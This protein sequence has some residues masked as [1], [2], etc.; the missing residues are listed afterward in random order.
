MSRPAEI[1]SP[2]LLAID[3]STGQAGLALYD[4]DL[5]AEVTWP[6]GR[7]GSRS[8]LV[9]VERL[10]SLAGCS[11]PEITAVAVALGPG[12][13]SALRVGLSAAKGLA[14]ALGCPIVGISTLDMT[15]HP[16]RYLDLPVWATIEAGRGRLVAA[17]Y[18]PLGDSWGARAAPIHGPV[19]RLLELI[20]G[21]ALVCGELSPAAEAALT[22]QPGVIVPG[23]ALRRRRAG[24][25]AELA[26]T[27][28][29][30]GQTDD[31]VTL[32]PIYLHGGEA[33]K[34]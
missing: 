13:F 19:E 29:C 10:L 22:G 21:P 28:L 4:G 6:A 20:A 23:P 17:P 14:F 34:G 9:E 30:A 11:V 27:R 18:G 3:S 7:H 1:R 33:G 24:S 2:L 5:R 16:H 25:L 15:A 32:E 26:W 31:P 8:I 12:S